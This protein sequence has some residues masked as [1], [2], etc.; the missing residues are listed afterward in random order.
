MSTE[1][2]FVWCD[3]SAYRPEATQGFYAQVFGWSFMEQH[4]YALGYSGIVAAAGIYQMP[5]EFMDMGL[6]SFWMSYIAVDDVARTVENARANGGIIELE[7]DDHALIRD[8]LGAG[9][10]VHSGREKGFS[11]PRNAHGLRT[12]HGYFCSDLLAVEPFYASLFGWRF[13]ASADGYTEILASDGTRLATALELPDAQRGKEQ[14]WAVR[15][16]V[17]DLGMATEQAGRAGATEILDVE[18]PEGPA[19]MIRDPDG[20][21]F[22][23]TEV[24]R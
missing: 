6:P 8:P 24:S 21:A 14:Y 23:I 19:A 7:A 13:N 12:G 15:F 5:S 3:L 22:F 1:G 17:A 18:L 4:G 10:T 11:P 9:F 16:G 20:A 2:S